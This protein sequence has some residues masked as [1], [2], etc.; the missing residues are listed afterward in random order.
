MKS[1]TACPARILYP[2][3]YF[4]ALEK[5]R[6]EEIRHAFLRLDSE[7]A[8]NCRHGTLAAVML[9]ASSEDWQKLREKAGA[10]DKK[11]QENLLD[12][13]AWQLSH[14]EF[15][16]PCLETENKSHKVCENM[17]KNIERIR[18]RISDLMELAYGP[19][20]LFETEA[21]AP[22]IDCAV[23]AESDGAQNPLKDLARFLEE[24]PQCLDLDPGGE[25]TVRSG[26]GLGHSYILKRDP[27]GGY[28]I[29]FPVEFS[30]DEDYDGE[31]SKE[32]APEHYRQRVQGC[33]EEASPMML[34]PKGEKLKISISEPP[35]G[36]AGSCQNGQLPNR[37]A[38]GP[39][40]YR[41]N[42]GKYEAD[43]DCPTIVHE[44]LHLSGLCDEYKE[45]ESG[46]YTDPETGKV[47][48][49]NFGKAK[50]EDL[51]FSGLDFKPAYDCRPLS[52]N[53]I[54]SNQYERWRNVKSGKNKS[55]LTNGQFKSLLY[56]SCPAKNRRFNG[57]S[58]LAYQ[59]SQTSE[60]GCLAAK[61]RCESEN[62]LGLDRREEEAAL[63]NQIQE[64]EA[65]KKHISDTIKSFRDQGSLNQTNQELHE[66]I[67]KSLEDDIKSKKGLLSQASSPAEKAQRE[68]ELKGL[69]EAQDRALQTYKKAKEM[70]ILDVTL[71]ERYN[72]QLED[73]DK[74][75]QD[76][77][78]RLKTVQSW[79]ES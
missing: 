62:A 33:L 3:L 53:S 57:C 73:F 25:K 8:E 14:A 23:K 22:C 19:E 69:I 77:R 70:G 5:I 7:C 42:S 21:A 26:N 6:D 45:R 58:R 52:S 16:A 74:E 32:D 56:G 10:A 71:G 20:A 38:I 28:S 41:S 9:Q 46:F 13:M 51:E 66:K 78:A 18:G 64:L 47:A 50:D 35:S 30:V 34:G 11:C 54:M 37:I 39:K 17:L 43:I 75:I 40:D 72:R 63:Q 4:P 44:I 31:A 61:S 76:A 48:G 12:E 68:Q 59:S 24:K 2:E 60:E 36:A 49:A 15:P 1:K 65:V 27:D 29:D 67:L 55:L 79:P